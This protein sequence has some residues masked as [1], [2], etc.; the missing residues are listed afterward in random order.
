MEVDPGPQTTS[1][2]ITRLGRDAG[3]SVADLG[4]LAD[5]VGTWMGGRGWELIALPAGQ[6]GGRETF[7]LLVRP[8]FEVMTF[9]PVGAPVPDRGGPNGDIFLTGLAY[10]LR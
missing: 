8:Y 4:P 6:P 5:L 7:R 3:T 1:V 9:T 10:E 2:G